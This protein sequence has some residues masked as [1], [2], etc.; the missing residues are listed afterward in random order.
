MCYIGRW[1]YTR[2]TQDLIK[3]VSEVKQKALIVALRATTLDA[4]KQKYK[5]L[6]E[7][8]PF[9]ALQIVAAGS[10]KSQQIVRNWEQQQYIKTFGITPDM[11]FYFKGHH[12]L[13]TVEGVST[14]IFGAIGRD[15]GMGTGIGVAAGI[16]VGLSVAG[17]VP[18]VAGIVTLGFIRCLR[19]EAN[20]I[21]IEIECLRKLLSIYVDAAMKILEQLTKQPYYKRD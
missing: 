4:I 9:V 6:R 18:V 20:A 15:V 1:D 7:R 21:K 19:D 14:G 16:A 17:L 10:L 13:S 11:E 5:V 12:E 2:F 8:I 3:N